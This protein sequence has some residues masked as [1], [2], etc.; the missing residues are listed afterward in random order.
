ML[1][2]FHTHTFPDKI[3]KNAIAGLE[4][5]SGL[6]ACTDGTLHGLKSSME[7]NQVDLSVI[8]PVAT[9][10]SQVSSI[11]YH[12]AENNTHLKETGILSFGAMHPEDPDYRKNLRWLKQQGFSGIKLHPDYQGHFFDDPLYLHILEEAESLGLY[13]VVH[14]GIDIGFPDCVHCSPSRIATV[15]QTLH[16]T[17]LILAHTG[18]WKQWDEV[19]DLLSDPDLYFDLSFSFGYISDECFLRILNAHG[20]QHFLFGTDSPWSDP[21]ET[22][23]HLKGL[24][25]PQE[26]LLHICYKNALSLLGLQPGDFLP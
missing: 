9:T 22:L 5:R 12:A 8:L 13:T 1:I 21:G 26:A 24:H 6:T 20:Y 23:A 18:G 4:A 15:L 25:L 16:P 14:A 19:E 10:V 2:D 7:K 11:N 3:A 17:H